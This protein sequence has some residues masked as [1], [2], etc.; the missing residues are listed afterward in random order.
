MFYVLVT[1]VAE[2]LKENTAESESVQDVLTVSPHNI[3]ILYLRKLREENY[4][5]WIVLHGQAKKN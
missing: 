5:N 4:R 2:N 1:N 3:K